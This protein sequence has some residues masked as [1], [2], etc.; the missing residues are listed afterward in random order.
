MLFFRLKQFNISQ[1]GHVFMKF[2]FAEHL[3][4][5]TKH[6]EAKNLLLMEYQSHQRNRSELKGPS[7][8]AAIKG[9]RPG[10]VIDLEIAEVSRPDRV[11]QRS[12]TVAAI[13][14]ADPP[15]FLH[16]F[17]TIGSGQKVKMCLPEPGFL[18]YRLEPPGSSAASPATHRP[19]LPAST[20]PI[21]SVARNSYDRGVASVSD[22]YTYQ[23]TVIHQPGYCSPIRRAA[24]PTN[25]ATTT[26][27]NGNYE[28]AIPDETSLRRTYRPTQFREDQTPLGSGYV[29]NQ[30]HSYISI[31]RHSVPPIS[32]AT[33][34]VRTR[35][36]RFYQRY[37]PMKISIVDELVDRW[38]GIENKLFEVLVEKY[39]PEPEDARTIDIS[40]PAA[41]T[42]CRSP[43]RMHLTRISEPLVEQNKTTILTT[44]SERNHQYFHHRPNS[45]HRTCYNSMDSVL[46]SQKREPC[47][48]NTESLESPQNTSSSTQTSIMQ[49]IPQPQ[50]SMSK[51]QENELNTGSGTTSPAAFLPSNISVSATSSISGRHDDRTKHVPNG[52][53]ENEHEAYQFVGAHFHK[54]SLSPMRQRFRPVSPTEHLSGDSV[55]EAAEIDKNSSALS[56]EQSKHGYDVEVEEH[57]MLF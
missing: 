22:P 21:V 48:T 12:V 29:T 38:R 18:I 51:Q 16:I 15:T 4:M 47:Q 5:Q 31:A 52:D 11:T 55:A 26:I 27:P 41:V 30:P 14:S 33:G 50:Q 34:D 35:L 43:S 36:T 44:N 19:N 53:N 45:Q 42:G 57:F 10:Q 17:T 6:T 40:S 2:N 9:L 13:D 8:Q 7:F 49:T 23:Q 20:T 1:N 32:G 37:N 28:R 54:A 56:S 3:F 46:A 25:V 39:G 24:M